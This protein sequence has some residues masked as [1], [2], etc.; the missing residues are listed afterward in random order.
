MAA[1]LAAV[2]VK[3]FAQEAGKPTPVTLDAAVDF[4]RRELEGFDSPAARAPRVRAVGMEDWREITRDSSIEEFDA[5]LERLV[6]TALCQAAIS[7]HFGFQTG[8]ARGHR[9]SCG[10]PRIRSRARRYRSAV[11]RVVTHPSG[12]RAVRG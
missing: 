3:E 12:E 9:S 5:A 1:C 4:L 2:L 8:S 10:T 6:Q 11:A 7:S